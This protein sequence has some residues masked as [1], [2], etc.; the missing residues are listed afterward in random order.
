MTTIPLS[1]KAETYLQTLCRVKP[2][3]T[4]GSEGNR[5][6][7]A[8][9]TGTMAELGWKIESEE[10]DCIDWTYG[11]A[12][13][14]V[15]G[16]SF[17]IFVGSYSL[18]CDVHAPLAVFSTIEELET[19]EVQDNI[20]LL[21]G[22]LVK[23][24][25]MPKGFPFYNPDHH[26]RLVGLL[27]EKQPLAIVAATGRDPG[28]AGGVY[29]FPL[30]EDG[31]F[32]IP[33]VYMK[34]VVGDRLA[35][36]GGQVVSLTSEALRTPAKGY[37]ITA[38]KGSDPN[39][40]IVIF[41]H[42]DAK[43]DTP[44]ALD[45]GTGV[46]VLLLLGELLADYAGDPAIELV[47]LNGED[48]YAASGE[49]LWIENNAGRFSEIVLGINIDAA[50]YCEVETAFSLYACPP[51]IDQAI[52]AAFAARPG[53]M[54]GEAWY[55]SD[56][57]MFIQNQVP[58]LAITSERFMELSTY[59]THTPKDSPELVDYDKVVDIAL[60]LRDLVLDLSQA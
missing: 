30:I 56:H 16:R 13:L 25:L 49:I 47:A 14:T 44:G 43:E 31:D 54:E 33:S 2:N 23:E 3:R 12:H 19:T 18:G 46:A 52:R 55:Q 9:F 35:E 27:E 42:I 58:A 26:R 32:D 38:R 29:P 36:Y 17:E 8:M 59:V 51:Q 5:V 21:R 10:F 41:G 6:A 60:A 15:A 34:D 22:D 53:V 50:G 40:R 4:V 1:K 57:S 28:L 24:Q 37:N 48:Y 39:R 7:T 11:D 45:N 20:V